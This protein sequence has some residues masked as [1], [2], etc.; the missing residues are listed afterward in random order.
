MIFKCKMCGGTL[1]VKE[2]QSIAECEFCGTKQ[3]IPVI[4]NEKSF[5]LHN[6][7]NA[8]RLRNEF[9]KAI[10][11]Y[12]NI[13]TDNPDDAEAHWG[14][15]LCKYGIEYVDDPL[16]GKKIPT[17]HRTQFDSVFSDPDYKAAIKNADVLA[18]EVY[19]TEAKEIDGI[20]KHIL[21]ISQKEERFDVFICYKESD[22]TGRRTI[23]SVIAQDLYSALTQK[24]YKVFFSKITLETKLGEMYE[25]YIFA[26]L[27]SAKVMLVIGTK[28][29]YFNAVWVRNEWSRFIKIMERDHDKY[30]IP[31][32]KDMDAYDLPMEMASF[33]A[34]DM[35]KI[36][37]LQDL[38]YGIDKLFGKTARPVKVE[39]KPTAVI[40]NGVNYSALL[41][42]AQILIED[43]DTK[44]ADSLLEKVL[45]N[46][47]KNAKAYFYKL[48]ID[49]NVKSADELNN[50]TRRISDEPNYIKAC[51]YADAAMK[52]ELDGYSS[53][54]EENIKRQKQEELYERCIKLYK[55]T[56]AGYA[57]EAANGFQKLGDYKDSRAYYERCVAR[58]EKAYDEAVNYIKIYNYSDA[59]CLLEDIKGYK[60]SVQLIENCCAL[61]NKE[62]VYRS[63]VSLTRYDSVNSLSAAIE[64]LKTIGDYRDSATLIE[65]YNQRINEIKQREEISKKRKMRFIKIASP[66]V[67]AV[68]AFTLLTVY[69]FIPLTK[70]NQAEKAYKNGNYDTAIALYDDL[71]RNHHDFKNAASKIKQTKYKKADSLVKAGKYDEAKKIFIAICNYKN[72]ADRINLTMAS[73]EFSDGDYI[74]GINFVIWAGGTVDVTFDVDGG[75]E[76]SNKRFFGNTEVTSKNIPSAVKVGYTF[77]K[78]EISE[79][80]VGTTLTDYDKYNASITLKAVYAANSYNLTYELNG[81]ACNN[82]TEE[83]VFGAGAELP[84]PARKG[85]TFDGWSFGENER[86]FAMPAETFGD[87]KLYANWTANAYTITYNANGGMLDD[88]TQ[89]VVYDSNVTLK[90]PSRDA[91]TFAGWYNGDVLVS[92]GVWT[93]ADNVTLV[94]RWTKINFKITYNLNGGTNDGNNPLS[95]VISEK[96]ITINDPAKTGYT[97]LGWSVS[98]SNEKRE[99]YVIEAGAWGDL[100]L[101]ANWQANTYAITYDYNDG[102]TAKTT[103]NVTFDSAYKLIVPTRNGYDFN[104]WYIGDEKITDGTY[105]T[106]SDITLK[107]TWK[108]ITYTISYDLGGGTVATANSTKYTVETATFTLNNPTKTGYTFTGWI[109][110][111]SD[112]KNLTAVIEKGSFGNLIFT[113]CYAA[114]NYTLSFNVNGGNESITAITVT[115]DKSFTLPTPAR[116]GYT[117][118]G[119]YNGVDIVADGIWKYVENIELTAQWTANADTK[120]RVEHW[121]ENADDDEYTLMNADELTGM[122]DSV[123]MP[124]VCTYEH[125]KS[126]DVQAV[127]ILPKGDLVVK[128]Y[129]TRNTYTVS[130]VTNG[131]YAP[132]VTQKYDSTLSVG[133]VR[134]GYEFGGWYYEPSLTTLFSGR[135]SGEDFTLYAYW[136]GETITSEFEYKIEGSV[137]TITKF[138]GNSTDVVVPTYINDTVVSV[139]GNRA[140]ENCAELKSIKF[141]FWSVKT[142]EG[143]AF[144]NCT[145]LTSVVIPDSVQSMG[146]ETFAGCSNLES[147]TIPFVGAKSGVKSTDSE[148]Y[149]F[150]YIFGTIEYTN[151]YFSRQHTKYDNG[152]IRTDDY[153]LPMSLKTV[154]VSGGEILDYAFENCMYIE[155]I[156]IPNSI[157]QIGEFAFLGCAYLKSFDI[158]QGVTEIKQE[159]FKSCASLVSITVPSNVTTLDD[160]CFSYCTSLTNITLPDG[161][162]KIDFYAFEGC[163]SLTN[164]VIPDSVTEIMGCVFA[165]CESLESLTVPCIGYTEGDYIYPIAGWFGSLWQTDKYDES[166]YYRIPGY[167]YTKDYTQN[168]TNYWG[169]PLSFKS[170]TFTKGENIFGL[171][172]LSSLTSVTLPQSAKTIEDWTFKDCNN[173]NRI[174]LPINLQKIGAFA[175]S[176][177]TKL[178]KVNIPDS[179]TIMREQ[180]FAY[181]SALND[182][183]IGLGLSQIPAY[184][185][186]S[187]GISSLILPDN[188]QKIGDGAFHS[189]ENLS[190]IIFGNALKEIG[191]KSFCLCSNLRELNIPQQVETLYSDSFNDCP[192]QTISVPAFAMEFLPKSRLVKVDIYSGTKILKSSFSDCSQLTSISLCETITVIG[193]NAFTRCT[194]L[195]QITL[196]NSITTIEEAAFLGCTSLTE[197]VLSNSLTAIG[198]SAFAE[199]TDLTEIVLP[200][201]LTTIGSFV[202]SNCN[203]IVEI[204]IPSSVTSIGN[205]V[206]YQSTS[207]ERYIVDDGNTTYSAVDG[208]LYNAEKTQFIA[209]P[210]A[211]KGIVKIPEGIKTIEMSFFNSA[212]VEEIILPDSLVTIEHHAFQDCQMQRITIGNG[213]KEVGALAFWGCA[214]LQGVYIKDLEAWCK[215]SFAYAQDVNPLEYAHNLY[216]NNQL[217]TTLVLPE[218]VTYLANNVFD[219]CTSIENIILHDKIKSIGNYALSAVAIKNVFYLG[220]KSQWEQI[221][222]ETF[223]V[224][225]TSICYYYSETEPALNAEGTAYD[226]NYWH[227][228]TDGI[229]PKIWEVETYG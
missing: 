214:Q 125:F 114:N 121:L 66:I 221:K 195:T 21:E 150:G 24:G 164:I 5:N 73:R 7:A 186:Q 62:A 170:V 151:S 88:N 168:S 182:L 59:A 61:R 219:G 47:P 127:T 128:Y 48:L 8:L 207:F 146:I 99:N 103:Q 33:Q 39:E 84:V 175:F 96:D 36:G 222:I 180:A 167:Y 210:A 38:L 85:Y 95:Y 68:I 67:A 145:G 32:Y 13:L 171:T 226:G 206:F 163:K 91:Y 192:L 4:D 213:L 1:D 228:D 161:L 63:A 9:D 129:Y 71:Y 162:Q 87:K 148:I 188:I 25:P 139:I 152:K 112:V 216:L 169:I 120:Y 187:S 10:I 81:G 23:D 135:M 102:A 18:R 160:N 51:R 17:C 157:T 133:V 227:Y 79:W 80:N 45:N 143:G 209:R 22:E 200:N 52:A 100:S 104:G 174:N 35:G 134:T 198:N 30:L 218:T 55:F 201:S 98:G 56:N 16:T 190:S 90:T 82:L 140:F 58:L 41:E 105:K 50:F 94:A 60:D 225:L 117:F 220:N 204:K 49:L 193:D 116:T 54:I 89:S 124:Q 173:L 75:T 156:S 106:A 40:Q 189:C 197:V 223:N 215:I 183:T 136:L 108:I 208:I 199:C 185:F 178:E 64:R 76:M 20:Q 26:A 166:K 191:E 97:F 74:D 184:A 144:Y 149:S 154:N 159:T 153:R 65:K 92:S 28:E 29:A 138:I 44:K 118:V 37:F 11:V 19:E 224:D 107:A 86:F 130:F 43:G 176:G 172:D 203:G 194:G 12:E 3:T 78:W 123:I 147:L 15:L 34:Q 181:C 69:L 70:Y 110:G 111:D 126:P 202:F 83:Y 177:C 27:N 77:V 155:N 212:K 205:S 158:P 31:C 142:I 46:D 229:T 179:V 165:N 2:G 115:Y 6:R 53:R 122:S 137:A 131:V 196:P 42:R 217:V 113:A 119:W 93:I 211:L 101:T 141:S 109:F 132:S 57:L 72:S 14:L